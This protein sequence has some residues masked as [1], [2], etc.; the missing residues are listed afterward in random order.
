MDGASVP[1]SCNCCPQS[2]HW[3]TNGDTEMLGRQ[4]TS[5]VGFKCPPTTASG[6]QSYCHPSGVHRGKQPHHRPMPCVT[7]KGV[8][9][10]AAP[11]LAVL[12]QGDLTLSSAVLRTERRHEGQKRLNHQLHKKPG[13]HAANEGPS[14]AGDTFRGQVLCVNGTWHQLLQFP[15]CQGNR[16][17]PCLVTM[18]LLGHSSFTNC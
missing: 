3:E 6:P 11:G 13:A 9:F 14:L 17:V 10:S 15:M 5:P 2:G 12:L 8:L 4:E 18:A 1:D 7:E 16:A